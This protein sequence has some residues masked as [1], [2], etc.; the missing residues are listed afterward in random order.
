MA[1]VL[2][3]L[4]LVLEGLLR[5]VLTFVLSEGLHAYNRYFALFS[6]KRAKELHFELGNGL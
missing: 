3:K 1:D 5:H 6:I 2:L 4:H